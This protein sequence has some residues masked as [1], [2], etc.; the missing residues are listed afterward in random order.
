MHEVNITECM[1]SATLGSHIPHNLTSSHLHYPKT[2]LTKTCTSFNT[3]CLVVTTSKPILKT[4]CS[5]CWSRLYVFISSRA[6]VITSCSRDWSTRYRWNTFEGGT[7]LMITMSCI[8]ACYSVCVHVCV[9][10]RV[11]VC[12]FAIWKNKN[13][14][15]IYKYIKI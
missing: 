7:L 15:H 9:C 6:T 14:A 5:W 1:Y 2:R 10:V 11:P 13:V 8:H 12:R 3:D 4:G